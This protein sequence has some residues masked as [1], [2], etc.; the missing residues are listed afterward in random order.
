MQ[1]LNC[2]LRIV[3][4]LPWWLN[5]ME[6]DSCDKQRSEDFSPGGRGMTLAEKVRQEIAEGRAV[7][8]ADGATRARARRDSSNRFLP[9]PGG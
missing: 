6:Y 8:F 1:S 3:I 2:R 5:E 4:L 7:S 9:R